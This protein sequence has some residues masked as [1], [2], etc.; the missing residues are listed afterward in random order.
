[1]SAYARPINIHR[2]YGFGPFSTTWYN[3]NRL[4]STHLFWFSIGQKL[5]MGPNTFLGIISD[6]VPSEP[7]LKGETV[8]Q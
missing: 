1:M 2:N 6:E 8:E 3:S 7:I 4:D 5:R